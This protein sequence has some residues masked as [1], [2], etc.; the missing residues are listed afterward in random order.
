MENMLKIMVLKFF[1]R[2]GNTERER[3]ENVG[4]HQLDDGGAACSGTE[5]GLS[6]NSLKEKVDVEVT[7]GKLEQF[8]PKSQ[9]KRN[10]KLFFGDETTALNALQTLA[11][12]SLMMPTSTV[13]SESSIQLK[14]ERMAAGKAYKYALPEAT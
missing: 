9:R 5:E 11:D 1:R 14:G 6:F 4:N 8:S 13:E 12:L 2:R 3:V 10:K 7:N